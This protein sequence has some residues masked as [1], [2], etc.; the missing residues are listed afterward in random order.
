MET[1]KNIERSTRAIIDLK[2]ISYNI[3][4][5]RKKIGNKRDLMAVVKADG[6]GHGAVQVSLSA[7]KSGANCLGVALPEEGRELRDA[8]IDVPILVLGLIKPEEA[9]KAIEFSLEQAVSSVE[10]AEALDQEARKASTHIK[11]HIKVDTGMG[12]IGVPPEDALAFA[13]EMTQFRHLNLTGI[14]SHFASADN[15]DKTFAKK[16]IALFN[17][18]I[19]EIEAA[20]IKIPKKHLANSAAI[21]DLPESYYDLVRPGIMI[22]GLYPSSEVGK[23]IRL[24]PAMTLKTNVI[25]VKSVPQGTPIS[26]G[27]TFY[28]SQDT[29]VAT[30]PVGYADG[31]SRILSNQAYA[32]VKGQRAPLIGRV[33]MDMCMLD[34]SGIDDVQS[35]EEVVL[36]GDNPTADEIAGKIGTINYELVCSVGKRVP[37]IYH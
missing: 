13:R 6:Y 17:A 25:F 3:S 14:F 35:G 19:R 18:V 15:S 9:Y 20:G 28:T 32:L 31:Y 10:L 5:I 1:R 23:T 27:P 21:L 30:L 34:V 7:L 11:V 22:Y 24:K 16:Q 4:E 37:R 33:C 36:F 8:G 29:V 2:A 12:R 26:Y